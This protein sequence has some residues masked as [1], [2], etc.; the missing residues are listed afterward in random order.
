MS[1]ANQLRGDRQYFGDKTLCHNWFENR[2]NP[3]YDYTNTKV[4]GTFVSNYTVMTANR[5]K[6]YLDDMKFANSAKN[7]IT[8]QTNV[9]DFNTTNQDFLS[10]KKRSSNSLQQ[11]QLKFRSVE[12]PY[13]QEWTQRKQDFSTT[14]NTFRVGNRTQY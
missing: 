6:S 13:K 14:A 9:K 7:V 3:I 8:F 10:A 11:A 1:G 2:C 12:K 4:Y 5:R